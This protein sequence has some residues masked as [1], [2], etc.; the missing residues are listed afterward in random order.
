M[1]AIKETLTK[2]FPDLGIILTRIDE[3]DKSHKLEIREKDR[4]I[5]ELNDKLDDLERDI[6]NKEDEIEE[7]E[8]DQSDLSHV[9]KRLLQNDLDTIGKMELFAEHFDKFNYFQLKEML[10]A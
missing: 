6:S 10:E 1:T 3:L 5:E 4:E 7:L 2:E 8:K 9:P